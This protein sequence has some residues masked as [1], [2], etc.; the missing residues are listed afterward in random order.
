MSKSCK[1]SGNSDHFRIF[2]MAGP[3][4]LVTMKNLLIFLALMMSLPAAPRLVPSHRPL[5]PTSYLEVVF[6][7]AMV[8][9]SEVAK[10]IGNEI[11]TIE[12]AWEVK[13]IW[14]A[15][16]IAR[17]IPKQAPVI[18]ASYQLTLKE[19]LK[20]EAGAEVP[21]PT[22]KAVPV[23]PFQV[24]KAVKRGSIRNGGLMLVFNDKVSAR[25]VGPYFQFMTPE[26][27]EQKLQMVA[28]RTRQAT[29]GDFSS[30]RYY[31]SQPWQEQFLKTAMNRERPAS[32]VLQNAVVI[33]PVRPLPIGKGWSVNR[34]PGVPNASASAVI[35]AANAYQIGDV[36][37]FEVRGISARTV[38]DGERYIRVF[39]NQALPS[40]LTGEQVLSLI[41]LEPKPGELKA[42]F[43]YRRQ[44]VTLSGGLDSGDSYQIKVPKNFSSADGLAL[45]KDHAL[46]LEF[47]R[48]KPKVVL[49]S[50]DQ[51][52][53][54]SGSRKYEI[55]SLNN[56]SVHV[57]IKRLAPDDLVRATQG[58]RHYTGDKGEGKRLKTTGP[59]PFVLIGGET[60]LDEEVQLK[61]SL[62][63]TAKHVID[64]D[65]L[66]PDGQKFGAFFVSV[67]GAPA[68]HPDLED[69]PSVMGQSIVQLTDLG[70]AW[71]ITNDSAFLYVYSCQTGKPLSGVEL[72]LFGENAE[73]L[74][75]VTTDESGVARLPRGEQFRHLRASFKGDAYV[76][77]Y[78]KSLPEVDM[79]RFPVNFSWSESAGTIRDAYIFSD[80]NLYRPGELVRL[81]GVVRK[82]DGEV[83]QM[84]EK[85][86]PTL[87]V[88]DPLGR[89]MVSRTITLSEVGSFDFEYR[90]P[91][92][93]VGRYRLELSWPKDLEKA[94]ELDNW[95][96]EQQLRKSAFFSHS[97]NVQEFKRNTFEEEATLVEN[98]SHELDYNLGARYFQGTPVAKAKANWYL[99]ARPTGI[100]P[101]KFRDFFFG[102]HRKYDSQYWAHYF[103]YRD[104]EESSHSGRHSQSGEAVLD[105][106]GK[107]SL[108]FELP[109]ID[110]PMPRQ[111]KVTTEITDA[112]SQTL[113]SSSSAKVHSSDFY[114]GISRHDRLTRVGEEIPFKFVAV[115]QKGE[116]YQDEV[117]ATLKV[118]REEHTQVKSKAA[119]G[120]MVVKNEKSIVP[121]REVVFKIPAGS[122]GFVL[123]FTPKD[124]GRHT[125]SLTTRD[126]SGRP[127]M[128][129]ATRQVYGS[130][131]YSWAYE[132]GMRIKL[133]PE[134][135]RYQPGEKARIL[136]LSPIEGEALVTMERRGVL[137]HFR[138]RL[139]LENPII[140]VPLSNED[141][142]NVFVS[143]LIIKG[144]ADSKR[145]HPE[146]QL[147]LGYCEL[148]VDPLAD[149]LQVEMAATQS[150]TRPGEAVQ[151][152]GRVLSSDGRPVPNAEL[153]FYAE[154]EG[155][156]SVAGYDNPNPLSHFHAPRVLET[157][158]GT[159]LENFIQET[160][161]ENYRANKGF[162]IGGGDGDGS[163]EEAISP[164]KNF[165]PCAAWMPDIRTGSDGQFAVSFIAPDTLTRYRL[166]A[167]VHEG[168]SRFGTGTSEAIV[169]KPVMLEPSPP[170]FA[171]QGDRIRPKA[172]LQNNSDHAGVWKVSLALDSLTGS[173]A[174]DSG[175]Q[176]GVLE[177][178]VELK[179]RSQ[180]TVDFDV[181]FRNAGTAKWIWSATPQSMNDPALRRSLSDAVESTFEIRYPM[182]LLTETRFVTFRDQ[183]K[184]HD[185]LE[186]FT[187]ELVDGVGELEL[188][189]ARSRLSEAGAAIDYLLHYPYGCLEQ[190]TS[191][192]IPWIAAKRLRH[193]APGF[194]K[195]S[196][197]QIAEAIQA[198]ADRLLSMQ[199][200]NGGLSYWPGNQNALPWASSYGG[201]GLIMCRDAG[202]KVPPKALN[203]LSSYLSGQLREISKAKTS[204][205]FEVLSRAL[206]VLAAL[207]KAEPAYHAKLLERVD[208]LSASPRGFL[209]L[210]MHEA[211]DKGALDLLKREPM[212]GM[213]TGYWMA[214][215]SNDAIKLLAWATISPSSE[216][217]EQSLNRLLQS[218]SKRGH[219]R[220]TWCNAWAL[221]GMG[222]YAEALEKE[223]KEIK[224]TLV[225][226][227]GKEEIVIPADR[228]SHKVRLPLY[229][230]LKVSAS[231]NQKVFVHATLGAKPRI[232]PVAP[233]S[234]SGVTVNRIYERVKSDGSTEPL[235]DPRT[236]DLV[237]VTLEVS[238]PRDDFRYLAIDDPLPSSFQ[239]INTDFASQAGRVKA[240]NSWRVSHQEIRSDRVVFFSDYPGRSGKFTASY[241]ARVTHAGDI[242][243]P[244][245]KVEEMYDP[246]NYALGASTRLIVK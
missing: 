242:Y 193:L 18:G 129:V 136:V 66:L 201:L 124:A 71:K 39:F 99:S 56:S 50:F 105:D 82:K 102:N 121:V 144:S 132:A 200:R 1:N 139:T 34:L 233:V 149:R 10:E 230:G 173:G 59:L 119:N 223:V 236:G 194:Q 171:H 62:D 98:E 221:L 32:E 13:V 38:V 182:P 21:R 162:V 215:R 118:T 45:G 106:E 53:L 26:T 42:S 134:Q 73:P 219:W 166:I 174:V 28:A 117:Q 128:T 68:D 227:E 228:A 241:H 140:E 125:F 155:T 181:H 115:D 240:N 127:V 70:L 29:W 197:S 212:K 52:Q 6:D 77:P 138:T 186:G 196:E 216:E 97:F 88:L 184:E 108:K 177:T 91:A 207:G 153:V 75:A 183:G 3:L 31:Y 61:S 5:Q 122:K 169:N 84:P 114:L 49:P 116:L 163:G 58:Y 113:S 222:A 199:T 218:R 159:S 238:L 95:R 189:F 107:V 48:A 211:G 178:F 14:R 47:T 46:G 8:P 123:P 160:P 67:T 137:R 191:S 33:E 152:K 41:H 4:Y 239:A 225:S 203:D 234:P 30:R 151:V 208:E 12:P 209:A 224:V 94:D 130:D 57:S 55:E 148:T 205:D 92:T 226:S 141:A 146:P 37:P 206:Y 135:S 220:T 69:S 89:E 170:L 111:V 44:S 185:L 198:G 35:E 101:D 246:E 17:L 24:V 86:N 204:R 142:P 165:D 131:E 157:R 51:A 245:T 192:T 72:S 187:Q 190:T 210:A 232:A 145:K 78:D 74:K 120:V 147:R 81:K 40:D 15:R 7:D 235:E 23:A 85:K 27:K 175:N 231:A 202:A 244:P 158:S 172:I 180:G 229:G 16:N 110:Y 83:F 243:V 93:T 103:G 11:V 64:W 96:E 79:W 104:D 213:E 156:L 63:K 87:K 112:N 179:P 164:R 36:I 2:A 176:V 76:L 25:E 109:A 188:E 19:G 168:V 20:N 161:G 9:Q 154:D 60:I 43:D 126:S 90:L 195:K 214:H 22:F 150:E 167:V 217:C 80:R 100:Y 54:A 237:K 133:V 65:Q 143:V